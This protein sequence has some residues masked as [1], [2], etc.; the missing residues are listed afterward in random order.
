LQ[1]K[2]DPRCFRIDVRQAPLLRGY[3]AR[4][5]TRKRWLLLILEHHLALTRRDGTAQ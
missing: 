2:Y 4:D 1:A 5:V 3:I